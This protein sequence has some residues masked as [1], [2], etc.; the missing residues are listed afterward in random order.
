M[1]GPR[2]R[3]GDP[4]GLVPGVP[5]SSARKL[6][7]DDCTTVR[8]LLL[9]VPFRYEDRTAFSKIAELESGQTALVAG[10]VVDHRL[11]RTRR[12][13][14]TILTA[15]IDDGTATLAVIW[16]NRPY[17]APAL[18]PGR[19]AVLFGTAT[20][21]KRGLV[22]KNPEHE[23]F[24]ADEATDSVH[25]GRVVGIYRKLGG[26]NAKW[27]RQAIARA[28]DALDPMFGAIGDPRLLRR[29]LSDVHFPPR[30]GH[31]AAAERARRVLAAEELSAFC[32]RIEEKREARAASA[33]APWKW[34]AATTR[35]LLSL[36][37]FALTGSQERAVAEI[38]AEFRS[39]RP[40]A[41]LLQGDVGSGKTAVAL[42]AAL[43]AAENGRQTALMAPTE[44][45]AEQ[46]A[47]TIGRWLDGSRYRPALL[48]GKTPAPA[49]RE[50][51][52]GLEAGEIDLLIGTHA[53]IEKPIRFAALGLV[54][55]DEQHRFGVEHR[56]RLSRKGERPHVL[57]LSATPIPRSLAWT[58]FGDL[59]VS[60][61]TEK[62]AGRAAI[63]TFVR[64]T[65]RREAVL[66]F[67]GER[68]SEGERAYVV[69]PAIDES[70]RD[71]AA[72]ERTASAIGRDVAA[73]RVEV[74]HGRLPP[75][76][77][78]S[79]MAKFV[80]GE[81]NV[82][83]ATTVVEV[84]IDVPEA[85]VMIVENAERFGLSQLHQLRGRVGRGARASY[86]I[87][88]ASD[89][90]GPEALARLAILRRSNDGFEIAERDLRLRGPGDLLGARQSGLPPFRVADP[91]GD[92]AI[93]GRARDE[94]HRR[95]A[96]GESIESELFPPERAATTS[97]ASVRPRGR[98]DGGATAV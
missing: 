41:R 63:R 92:V 22:M 30:R 2:L 94:I 6:A 96:R 43:L 11:V 38:A 75:P 91:V 54:V 65:A 71:V 29:A 34:T 77:R 3:L 10:R 57:V 73:A 35:R 79:A 51:R 67:V 64:P 60:R 59:D 70:E 72:V 49:R 52:A 97:A 90:A 7:A 61:L 68:L 58:L 69:V 24:D 39:G 93:L 85:T 76:R 9:H 4:V 81:A 46:H 1:T 50:L 23:L 62:P 27:Q 89:D 33:I 80:S 37:P 98:D 84:G 14:F 86:C 74:L 40:M 20:L 8:D 55:V 44:I 53:L 47:D 82:L 95:R 88:F 16:F 78:R 83:V 48:T 25:M 45:L 15:A 56:A 42:L 26:L 31:A 12:R 36:L 28:L 5:P 66:R 21:E 17:L 13:G 32:A 19:R 18:R 87:L